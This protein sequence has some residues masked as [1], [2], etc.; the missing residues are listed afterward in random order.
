MSLRVRV[1]SDK[2]AESSPAYP[3]SP[4]SFEVWDG[5][6][7]VESQTDCKLE[8][9]DGTLL[10]SCYEYKAEKNAYQQR[11]LIF[12]QCCIS[13]AAFCGSGLLISMLTR[14]GEKDFLP[15]RNKGLL[16]E[17]FPQGLVS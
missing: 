4:K 15:N 17:C 1:C 5:R 13:V 14:A 12:G 9:F 16:S 11:R 10:G 7:I 6:S 3:D 2:L 8:R